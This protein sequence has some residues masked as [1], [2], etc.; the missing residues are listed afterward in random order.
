[1]KRCPRCHSHNADTQVFCH[2]CGMLLVP[3]ATQ[4]MAA[5]Q[6]VPASRPVQTEEVEGRPMAFVRLGAKDVLH[7]CLVKKYAC[8]DGR[9]SIREL[10]MFMG[11]ILITFLVA[12]VLCMILAWCVYTGVGYAPHTLTWVGCI[13]GIGAFLLALPVLAVCVRRL[14]DSG[15]SGRFLL[16]GLIPIAGTLLLLFYLL[17]PGQR[18]RNRYG[19][20]QVMV[21]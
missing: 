10:W 15:H 2:R 6:P 1:M 13:L 8:F 11:L 18:R 20:Y 17:L 3:P 21:H 16:L 19:S 5:E 12:F 7:T 14:H 9:A 4:A